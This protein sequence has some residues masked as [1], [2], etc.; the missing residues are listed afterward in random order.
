MSC[1]AGHVWTRAEVADTEP[2]R[3][4]LNPARASRYGTSRA[5]PVWLPGAV[6][7]GLALLVAAV[8]LLVSL[9]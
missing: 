7:G 5:L 4:A 9:T 6:L 8:D 3:P 2:G 1:K